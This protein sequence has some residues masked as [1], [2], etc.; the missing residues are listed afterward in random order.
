MLTQTLTE[1]QRA[2]ARRILANEA[3]RRGLA[4][5]TAAEL[6]SRPLWPPKFCQPHARSAWAFVQHLR[7]WNEAEQA[8]QP[9]PDKAYLRKWTREWVRCWRRG[10]PLIIEKSRRLVASWLFR[11]LELWALGL[12]RGD[13]II[14][15]LTNEDAAGHVWRIFHLYDDLRKRFPSWRLAMATTWG[16]ELSYKLDSLALP[17]GSKVEKHYDAADALQG[18]GYA[19][20]T[21]EELSKYRHPSAFWSQ[22]AFIT[23]GSAGG[24][25]GFMCAITNSDPDPNWREIKDF[26]NARDLLGFNS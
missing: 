16:N 18:S 1:A 7:T 15:H 9:F 6:A 19:G 22:A 21:A 14:A 13:W 4:L 12:R 10:Q 26:L 24:K 8:V 2:E 3:R 17:N 5:Q 25:N 20:I 11:A 23:Q